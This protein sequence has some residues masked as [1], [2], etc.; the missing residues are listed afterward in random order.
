M[1]QRLAVFSHTATS[2][3]R[4]SLNNGKG[5]TFPTSQQH[6]S[7]LVP[8]GNP[9][10]AGNIAPTVNS[11][12]PVCVAPGGRGNPQVPS[13]LHSTP[14]RNALSRK[15]EPRD[16]RN[17]ALRSR[18]HAATEGKDRAGTLAVRVCRVRKQHQALSGPRSPWQAR[19][20]R[21]CKDGRVPRLK[22][23]Q[24]YRM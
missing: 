23:P 18:P 21:I 16:C 24:L 15:Q 10:S 19:L 17:A 1:S 5:S 20:Q 3:K 4:I 9:P 14:S 13:C 7:A 22:A 12:P 11:R 6:Y 2:F 8:V